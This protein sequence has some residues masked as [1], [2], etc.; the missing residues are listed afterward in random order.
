MIER[1]RFLTMSASGVALGA[2]AMVVPSSVAEAATATHGAAVRFK[3]WTR[4]RGAA[5]HA[6]DAH[7]H[8]FPLTVQHVVENPS[9][10]GGRG[11]AFHVVLRAR[12][13]KLHD[14]I[15]RLQHR[16]LGGSADL[17]LVGSG[18]RTAT[19]S[20]DTRTGRK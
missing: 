1:R 13:R 11:E 6:R 5:I 15:Y 18:A 12:S 19:L 3:S 7:G 17:F 4:L 16:D 20:V 8:R 10:G 9:I 2:A 14:G